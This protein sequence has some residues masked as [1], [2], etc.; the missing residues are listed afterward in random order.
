MALRSDV[1]L[2]ESPLKTNGVIEKKE[3]GGLHGDKRGVQPTAILFLS[4]DVD[5]TS[6]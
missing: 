5:R 6:L 4:Q 2:P 1:G 3:I